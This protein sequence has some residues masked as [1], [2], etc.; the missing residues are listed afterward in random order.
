MNIVVKYLLPMFIS[1]ICLAGGPDL[2]EQ[3]SKLSEKNGNFEICDI[4]ALSDGGTISICLLVDSG[5]L[6]LTNRSDI[7]AHWSAVY[8]PKEGSDEPINISD[9]DAD[10]LL[11]GWLMHRYSC[12]A[13]VDIQ[14]DKFEASNRDDLIAATIVELVPIPTA[15]NN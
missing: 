4:Q 11:S 10:L 13:I 5:K 2:S 1:Q 14:T 9:S 8:E 6:W 3:V 7:R 12:K 15:C